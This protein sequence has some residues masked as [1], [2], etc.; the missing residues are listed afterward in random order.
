MNTISN[1]CAWP[2]CYS[3]GS[4]SWYFALSL[5]G[6]GID[7]SQGTYIESGNGRTLRYGGVQTNILYQNEGQNQPTPNNPL[8]VIVVVIALVIFVFWLGI[9]IIQ[10]IYKQY[11]QPKPDPDKGNDP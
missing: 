3:G 8:L 2:L 1:D 7:Q 9:T 6:A 11:T 4:N 10:H 5:I